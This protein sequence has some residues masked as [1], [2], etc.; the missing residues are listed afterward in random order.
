MDTFDFLFD[1][2]MLENEA[3]SNKENNEFKKKIH[4]TVYYY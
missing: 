3:S 1:E 4:P 2:E